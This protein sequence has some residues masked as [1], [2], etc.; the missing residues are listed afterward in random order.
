MRLAL[1]QRQRLFRDGLGDLLAAEDDIDVV[2]AAATSEELLEV[3]QREGPDVVLVEAD[4][5]EWDPGRL[6]VGLRRLL[7]Q[8]RVV[9]VTATPAG[10]ADVSRARRNGMRDIV[11]RS[12]GIAEILAAA[13][14]TSNV[15][16]ATLLPFASAPS[17]HGT[18]LTERELDVLNLVGAGF[19]SR[20]ISGL[21]GISHKTVENHKQRIFGKL[22][23]QNQAHAVSIA[24]RTGVLRPERVIDLALAD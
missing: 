18:A 7:P 3:C 21:L 23:V 19:T 10:P 20:E 6:V 1:Q 24:M 13:R 11:S 16:R 17:G 12:G 9:G 4:A 14:S 8:V 15:R 2:G 22:G 5:T